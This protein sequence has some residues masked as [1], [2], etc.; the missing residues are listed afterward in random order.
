MQNEYQVDSYELLQMEMVATNIKSL[1]VIV[2]DNA[3]HDTSE[4]V[5]P[6]FLF[7]LQNIISDNYVKNF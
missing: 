7:F 2:T 4:T 3:G 6:I 5:S 1:T